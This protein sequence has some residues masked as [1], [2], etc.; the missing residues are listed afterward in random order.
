MNENYEKLLDLLLKLKNDYYASALKL[1]LETEIIS[2]AEID[3]VKS[4]VDD[5]K[6]DLTVKVSGCS[7]VSDIFLCKA[8]Q[9][10]N[11]FVPM[12]ESPYALNKFYKNIKNILDDNSVNL[13]FN[14]ETI[15]ALNS[16]DEI[17]ECEN[18]DKFNSVVFGRNDFCSSIGK[19]ADY[20]D[21]N[22][23]FD[24]AKNILKKAESK[25][26]NFV[27]GGNISMSSFDFMKRLS[28]RKFKNFETRKITF[29]TK[30]LETDFQKALL[31]ALEFEFLWLNSKSF[32][33]VVDE[34]RK[35]LIQQRLA[36]VM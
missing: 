13:L 14:I 15:N 25:N 9:A 7:A 18:L 11:I 28:C 31:L 6:L 8:L 26:L 1:E 3:L 12:V 36:S 23:I 10:K 24:V 29:N 4:L 27:L 2:T 16:M 19:N 17:F 33:N 32:E 34:K 22:E 21:S 35:L 30:C 20:V 5:A